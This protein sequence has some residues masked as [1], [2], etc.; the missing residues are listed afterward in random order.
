MRGWAARWLSAAGQG[1]VVGMGLTLNIPDSVLQGLR[2]P[3]EEVAQRLRTELAIVLYAQGA[4]SLGKA[5]ELSQMNRMVF[6]ELVGQRGIARH[7]GDAELA[8]D[9][10]Y[11]R[12]E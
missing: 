3:E 12:G 9:V 4:L 6:G 10:S 8:Q 1:I 11:G 2:I 5:A 7:Y